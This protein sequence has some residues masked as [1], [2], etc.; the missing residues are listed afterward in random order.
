MASNIAVTALQG[1]LPEAAQRA[2]QFII[3]AREGQLDEIFI[4]PEDLGEWHAPVK[5]IAEA[6]R[7]AAFGVGGSRENAMAIIKRIVANYCKE[8]EPFNVLMNSD[9]AAEDEADEELVTEADVPPLPERSTIDTVKARLGMRAIN[10]FVEYSMRWSP[11]AARCYHVNAAIW[12]YSAL[13]ARRIVIKGLGKP[14]YTGL[15]FFFVG[16]T[17]VG[18]SEVADNAAFVLETLGV[19]DYLMSTSKITPE[20]FKRIAAGYINDDWDSMSDAEQEEAKIAL[21]FHGKTAL[22]SDEFGQ[23]LRRITNP[24]GYMFEW[25]SMLLSW[26]N[27]SAR[28]GQGSIANGTQKIRNPYMPMLGCMTISNIKK[29]PPA[30]DIWE[31][32]LIARSIPIVS[33]PKGYEE[34]ELVT[35]DMHVPAPYL[36]SLQQY[37]RRLGLPKIDVVKREKAKD[38]DKGNKKYEIEWIEDYPLVE[39]TLDDD[40]KRIF[41]NYRNDIGKISYN[42]DLVPELLHG[43]YKRLAKKALAVAAMLTVYDSD[44]VIDAEHMWAALSIAEEWRASLHLFYAQCFAP[45]V[46]VKKGTDD[47]MMKFIEKMS[48]QKKWVSMSQISNWCNKAPEELEKPLELRIKQGDIVRA[49]RIAKSTGKIYHSYAVPNTPVPAGYTVS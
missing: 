32:G 16:P 27:S 35:G 46:S 29:L 40:A 22:H 6:Y 38:S 30:S 49:V 7:L 39:V 21:G 8:S 20:A 31:N 26:E 37:H 12:L 48:K 25:L 5:E 28:D 44:T 41:N 34:S 1:I 4:V 23:L 15:Y 33:I 18:K 17:S 42:R 43:N 47:S 10:D 45:P 19:A 3:E 24:N 36:L 2:K 14:I 9:E 13:T 11:F